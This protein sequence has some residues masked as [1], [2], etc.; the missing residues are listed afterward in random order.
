MQPVAET[1]GKG[2]V[3]QIVDGIAER[4]IVVVEQFLPSETIAGIC[5]EVVL[6][7]AE[8]VFRPAGIGAGGDFRT[9]DD[10]RGDEIFWIEPG[11]ASGAVGDTL[12]AFEQ[13][14]Q[15]FNRELYLGL[16]DFECH[17][18]RYSPGKGYQRHYDQLRGDGRRLLTVTLYLNEGWSRADGGELRVYVDENNPLRTLDVMPMG[19]KLVA[20]QSARFAHEVLPCT[21]ERLSFT[22]WFRQR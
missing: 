8:G 9:R 4:G 18:A 14:R 7:R 19:G 21:R 10:I 13:L 11:A 17:L 2:I 15:A 6:M 22:G 5:S 16:C 1:R 20:F 3:R 12:A